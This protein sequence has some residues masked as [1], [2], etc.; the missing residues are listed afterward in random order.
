MKSFARFCSFVAITTCLLLPLMGL[1]DAQQRVEAEIESLESAAVVIAPAAD[2][3]LHDSFNRQKNM[4]QALML[5]EEFEHQAFASSIFALISS[6]SPGGLFFEEIC[7]DFASGKITVDA[8]FVDQ[9]APELLW[10]NLT[11]QPAFK[12]I[13]LQ[14]PD[15]ASQILLPCSISAVLQRD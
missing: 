1:H 15:R 13:N 12:E 4:D 3:V 2:V 9:R 10:K 8:L 6:I 11:Q 5:T 14:M 7:F